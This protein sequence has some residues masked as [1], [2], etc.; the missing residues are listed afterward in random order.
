MFNNDNFDVCVLPLI[1]KRSGEAVRNQYNIILTTSDSI[2]YIFQSYESKCAIVIYKNGHRTLV[3]YP[4]A[5]CSKTTSKYFHTWIQDKNLG[6]YYSLAK[7]YFKT[8]KEAKVY[9]MEID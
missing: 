8:H 4:E 1:S 7:D 9:T 6:F 2:H 5:F 3:V